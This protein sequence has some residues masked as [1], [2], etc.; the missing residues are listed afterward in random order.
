[1]TRN[2]FLD[3]LTHSW[4]LG[5]GATFMTTSSRCAWTQTWHQHTVWKPIFWMVPLY[6]TGQATE[7]TL[8]SWCWSEREFCSHK[9]VSF[10]F[11]NIHSS[12]KTTELC[13]Q[14]MGFLFWYVGK[15]EKQIADWLANFLFKVPEMWLCTVVYIKSS[16]MFHSIH[17]SDKFYFYY[18]SESS[19]QFADLSIYYQLLICKY[20]VF[21]PC[22][23]VKAE[24]FGRVG[25]CGTFGGRSKWIM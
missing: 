3:C 23:Q 24:G 17:A 6:M 8:W 16:V 13:G 14:Y 21:Y 19:M 9:G 4:A 12:H 1:M 20:L 25:D 11:L 15:V 5:Y 18:F 22:C 2:A 10:A 7:L